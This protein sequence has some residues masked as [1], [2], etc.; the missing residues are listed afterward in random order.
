MANNV[1]LNSKDHRE[2]RVHQGYSAKLGDNVMWT[3][4]FVAEFKTVQAHYP[5]VFQ[6]QEDEKGFIPVIL[7]G[8]ENNENLFLLDDGWDASYVPLLIQRIPFSIGLY[9]DAAV[10]EKKKM[11]HVDLDHPKVT[12]D[13]SGER[14]FRDD[15]SVTDYLDR[16]SGML[17]TIHQAQEGDRKFVK[18]L[19]ELDLLE[20]VSM[21]IKLANGSEGQLMGFHIVNED[22][23][24][25]LSS[26]QLGRLH[27]HG[28]L[29]SIFMTIASLGKIQNLIDR[30]SKK[31][32]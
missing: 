30:K 7:L 18:K 10:G 15:G 11:I 12:S 23:L 26:E 9:D 13:G 19:E 27:S 14:L 6:Q 28:W 24:A 22:K 29:E 32:V 5:I 31:V 1:L 20:P 16:I 25:G 21:D 4:T 2:L 3:P 8:L 17:E